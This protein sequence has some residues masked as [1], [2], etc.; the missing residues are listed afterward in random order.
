VWEVNIVEINRKRTFLVLIACLFVLV[1]FQSIS[2]AS[3]IYYTNFSEY[4]TGNIPDYTGNMENAP[5]GTFIAHN[6]DDEE[7]AIW[8]IKEDGEKEGG[9]YLD[10]I[11]N[12]T[13]GS[14]YHTTQITGTFYVAFKG[15]SAIF[16]IFGENHIIYHS[17]YIRISNKTNLICKIIWDGEKYTG[18]QCKSSFSEE[19]GEIQGLS[20]WG[21][22]LTGLKL[23]QFFSS[24]NDINLDIFYI[25]TT[26]PNNWNQTPTVE[27]TDGPTGTIDYNDVTFIWSGSDS[28]G[29]VS[30]YYYGLDNASPDIWTTETTHTFNDVS[31]GTHIF[32]VQAKDNQGATS[33]V[34]N[35]T[36]TYA[37]VVNQP[38]TVE[39]TDGPT[40]TIDYNDVTF[41]WSGS[42]SDGEVSGY[43]YGL[44]NA[45][46][47]I[48]TTETTHTFNDVSEGN[49]TFYVQAKDNDGA[50]SSAASRSFT[51]TDART[52]YAIIAAGSGSWR[53][54]WIVNRKA[55][56]AYN[57]LCGLGFDEDDI[58]YLNNDK[59]NEVDVDSTKNNF[60]EAISERAIQ[61]VG[62]DDPLVIFMVGHGDIGVFEFDIYNNNE[63]ILGREIEECL[64]KLPEGTK[65]LIVI[66]AC[67]SGSFITNSLDSLSS[68]N[69]VIVTS[70]RA[71]QKILPY[72]SSFTGDFWYFLNEQS[73]YN[74]QEA[75][76]K[77]SQISSELMRQGEPQF[78]DP[79]G[80]A[81]NMSIFKQSGPTI[82]IE[83]I[84]WSTLCSPG[85]LRVYDSKGHITGLVNGS[86]KEEIPDSIYIVESKTVIIWPPVD[87]YYNEVVGTDLGTYGLN[88]IN[89]SDNNSLFLAIDIPTTLGAIHRYSVDWNAL[90]QGNDGVTVQVDSDGNG[91][92]E[93]TFTSNDELTQAEFLKETNQTIS[94]SPTPS[95][96]SIIGDFGST[97]NGPP[98][99]KVDS[100]DLMIFSLAYDSTSGDDNWNANCDIA[101]EGGVL[102]PDG[103]IDFEDLAVFSLYYGKNCSDQ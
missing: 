2:I 34:V 14:Y 38:P 76:D 36:F 51:Y 7:E 30:G 81:S 43:Y 20:G 11:T 101:S 75:F 70:C 13:Y 58:F 88:I 90:S 55:N 3:Q 29:E 46:P 77:A 35:Q 15:Y 63:Y 72:F 79:S 33:S 23:F 64:S 69:R 65:I 24:S 82:D 50:T 73:G 78:D 93:D 83:D 59:Y 31:E 41:T 60:K 87:T 96:Q 16:D 84:M 25:G 54:K 8:E 32:Y 22:P 62:P 66:D 92:F 91:N 6:S 99:C 17:S 12:Y 10:Q 18:Y 67:Y 74:V 26:E 1:L 27:I 44:D 61:R 9:K 102:K 42:D 97:N 94:P 56:L 86:A 68:N 5:E 85:E 40:G 49:H 19:Y 53:E 48:W 37:P 57:V 4:E 45:S 52:G 47:D 89:N 39:I 21:D 28:D 80:I 71:N 100:E 103:V 95:Q 98:D